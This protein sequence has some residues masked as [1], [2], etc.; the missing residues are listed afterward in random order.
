[1]FV[2]GRGS[3][4][5]KNAGSSKQSRIV[6]DLGTSAEGEKRRASLRRNESAGKN[7]QQGEKKKKVVIC[8]PRKN[9]RD[10]KGGSRRRRKLSNCRAIY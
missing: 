6:G 7:L 2:K 10:L 4:K 3:L 8:I 1:M 5:G 9:K